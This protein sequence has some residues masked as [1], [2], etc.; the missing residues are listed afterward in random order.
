MLP[1]PSPRRTLALFGSLLSFAL[2]GA[3]QE[4][5]Y[6]PGA[7]KGDGAAGTGGTDDAAIPGSGMDFGFVLPDGSGQT[8]PD[9]GMGTGVDLPPLPTG[10]VCGDSKV[11]AP[12]TCDD[13]NSTPGDGCSGV[14]NIEPNYQ[15]PPGGGACV[16]LVVCGDGKLTGSEACD[17]G[18]K[19]DADGCTAMCTVELGWTC[20][21]PGMPCVKTVNPRCG[22]GSIDV[23]EGC[24]DTNILSGDGCTSTCQREPGWKCPTPGMKCIKDPYCGDKSLD[25]GEQCDDGNNAPADGCTGACTKEPF[26]ECP[27]P[28][29]PCVS[30]IVCGDSK[31]TGDEACDDGNNVNGDGCAMGCKQVEG[32]Y[33]CP[34]S[35]GTGG[36]CTKVF[37]P[38]CGDGML[39]FGEVCDDGGK[40]DGDGCSADCKTVQ[41]GWK[42]PT[43]G[44]KCSLIAVCGDGVLSPGEQCDDGNASATLDGC[45]A[46]CIL[47]QDWICPTPNSPC[48][49]TVICGDGKLGGQEI[50]DD[51]NTAGG[52]TGTDGCSSDCKTIGTGWDCTIT[53]IACK[54]KLCGDG[55]KR[56]LEGCDDG[57]AV[58]ND[59]C[60][61][62]VVDGQK[63]ADDFGWVCTE[64]TNGKSTCAHTTC[65]NSTAKEGSE[66]C[67]DMKNASLLD[68]CTPQC[69]AVPKCPEG[70]GPC[71][72]ECGDGMILPGD[73]GQECDDGNVS[74][75]DG[76]SAT[77]KREPGYECTEID[78]PVDLSKVPTIFRDFKPYNVAGGH[79]DFERYGTNLTPRIV[80]DVLG[81]DGQPTHRKDAMG[82]WIDYAVTNNDPP[83]GT[84]VDYFSCW[85]RNAGMCAPYVQTITGFLGMTVAGT[86]YSFTSPGAGFFPIDN[87]GWGNN[88]NNNAHNWGFTTE[89]RAWFQYKG[90][91]TLE[92]FGDDDT[93]V[94]INKKL[95]VDLGGMHTARRGRV[96]L[97]DAA[98]GGAVTVCDFQAPGF[99]NDC[100]TTAPPG[101][102]FRTLSTANG[103]DLGLGVG[104]VYEIA[105][106]QAERHSTQSSYKLTF[107]QFNAKKSSC[108][109][110][111][112]DHFPTPDE[113]CDEGSTGNTGAYGGCTSM[114]K[115]G[116]RCGDNVINGPVGG[117]LEQCDD[118]L[119]KAPAY[120][121]AVKACQNGCKWSGYCGD[122]VVNGP[123]QCD[124]GTNIGGYG[125]CNQDCTKA[126]YCGD[127]VSN[128]A[129]GEECDDAAANGTPTS[130]CTTLCK[131]KCGNGTPDPGEQ[132]DNGTANNTG[133]YGK[134]TP[135]CKLAPRCG[136]GIRQ[137]ANEACDDGK[138]DG[139]YG[140]CGP[141][142]VLGPRCGD[143]VIQAQNGEQCDNG[144]A[145]M[146]MPYGKNLCDLRCQVAPFCG[147]KQVDSPQEK[148]DDGM[149]TG[150]P[151]SCKVDC[152]DYVPLP[153]CGDG[154]MQPGE[155]C[156][157][158][159]AN[160]TVGS[161]CDIHCKLKCGNGTRDPGE[162]CDDGVNDGKYGT[163]NPNCTLANYCGD[164]VKG[165]PEQCDQ[166]AGN[167]A[168]PYGPGKCTTNCFIGPYCG[169]GRIQMEYGEKCDSTPECNNMC[170]PIVIF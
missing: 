26:Y 95:A 64:D 90:G 149:N 8:P 71:N 78:A 54:A 166:G 33:T 89:A 3:C 34:N 146:S 42:C 48:Q 137:P 122:M 2:A 114:C 157:S 84:N 105:V 77:C 74:P 37:V 93:W 111:C 147:D 138:N 23:G 52:L 72:T 13:S 97:G 87:A 9:V 169:D 82:N 43:P 12:E 60:T 67:D 131:L 69:H 116:P 6:S 121:G 129:N 104:N 18:N 134:C 14:C 17:D 109:T 98:N 167:M 20:N 53:G 103:N 118:G 160:G 56:G 1:V 125:G 16:S 27:T 135:D 143:S 123:E 40:V 86:T 11:E 29:M 141:M 49:Y 24:D 68:G 80:A 142:C 7:S 117:P 22:D 140:T 152:S 65:G 39:S 161:T 153:S 108:K 132:C 63:P 124:L 159:P 156:D 155:Q 113:Q 83:P 100:P 41:Q 79:P 126:A 163:C 133:G 158:G 21:L 92:F 94:F 55:I 88:A 99:N 151:G 36:M 148:C 102:P 150:Q 75:G 58:A 119:N 46:T 85:Y 47:Q 66:Q 106:F 164:G 130:K 101:A 107:T 110:K 70:G 154:I 62:C 168:A 25:P 73:V 144:A 120:T 15:C 59:G 61:N 76:C 28:G 44:M 162:A 115:L 136:D 4:R 5:V 50:C 51:K 32:G 81:A 31:V 35:N 38:V 96:I 112:G 145:N 127:G 139:S 170:Q 19:V 30:T 165:G 91:E 128:T 10:P 57:N 45:S